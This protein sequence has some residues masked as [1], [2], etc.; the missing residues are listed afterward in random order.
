MFRVIQRVAGRENPITALR[1]F[2]HTLQFRDGVA[3]I[4]AL[5][6]REI[7]RLRAFGFRVERDTGRESRG[8]R[9]PPPTATEQAQV[10][11]EA[12]TGTAVPEDP[13]APPV[14]DAPVTVAR[15]KDNAAKRS[16]KKQ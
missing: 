1:V 10:A 2:E 4:A 12:A 15:P 3:T 8:E 9:L 6:E 14:A 13:E 7:V 16:H 5:T 11:Y